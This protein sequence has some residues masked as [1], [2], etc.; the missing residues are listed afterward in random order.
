MIPEKNKEG[1]II[2][3]QI[4]KRR[5]ILTLRTTDLQIISVNTVEN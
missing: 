3:Q 4:I 1:R 5:K 2:K